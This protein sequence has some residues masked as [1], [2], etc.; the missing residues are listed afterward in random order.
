LV[1]RVGGAQEPTPTSFDLSLD[2]SAFATTGLQQ[3]STVG[4]W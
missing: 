1:T 3:H 2:I 4:G